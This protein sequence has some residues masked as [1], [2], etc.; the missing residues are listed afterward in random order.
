M[1]EEW[2]V[3][4]WSQNVHHLAQQMVQRLMGTVATENGNPSKRIGLDQLGAM[5][6][7]RGRPSRFA[8][9]P[10]VSSNESRRWINPNIWRFGKLA[11]TWDQFETIHLLTSEYTK[12]GA[13]DMSRF[14]DEIVVG[15]FPSTLT[16][17]TQILGGALGAVDEGEESTVSVPFD[18]TNQLIVDGGVGFT[19]QKIIDSHVKFLEADYERGFHGP[20]T[21]VYAPQGLSTLLADTE[22]TSIE[23]VAVQSLMSGLPAPGLMGYDNWISYTGLPKVSTLRRYVAYASEAVVMGMWT[24][25]FA[26]ASERED[27]SY[28]P[29]MYMQ[30]E[31]GAARRDDKLVVAID[32]VEA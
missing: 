13:A 27:L 29:Q 1:I 9:T 2:L 8:P 10:N 3:E 11:D 31:R 25:G 5:S 26:R 30:E 6:G 15:T 24:T 20:R 12:A 32:V 28:V 18:T 22:L 21:M 14:H 4:R 16:A 23:F 19:K 17:F 7:E